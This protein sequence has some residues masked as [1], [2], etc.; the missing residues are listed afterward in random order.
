MVIVYCVGRKSTSLKKLNSLVNIKF[1]RWM[2]AVLINLI[3]LTCKAK[4]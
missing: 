4:M 3:T 2:P 1:G